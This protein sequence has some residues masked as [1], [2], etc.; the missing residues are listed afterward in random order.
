MCNFVTQFFHSGWILP[1]YNSNSIIL[2]LKPKDVDSMYAGC[3][4]PF[5]KASINNIKALKDLFINYTTASRQVVNAS[6]SFV[7]VGTISPNKISCIMS[8][9]S[10][11]QGTLPF[12]YLR[13]PLFRGSVKSAYLQSIASKIFSK[14]AAWKGSIL[15]MADRTM[16]VKFINHD[17]LLHSMSIYSGPT[18]LLKQLEK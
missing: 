4:P 1:N 6:K 5:C 10:F 16:L 14:L 2:V 7:Y 12:T 13:V 3:Y 11:S 15:S 17:I 9:T 18:F 8:L